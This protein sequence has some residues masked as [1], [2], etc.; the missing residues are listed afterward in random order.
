MRLKDKVALLTGTGHHEESKNHYHIFI[1][2]R[3]A[4]NP[5]VMEK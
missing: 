3:N 4:Q 2:P 5:F 1:T